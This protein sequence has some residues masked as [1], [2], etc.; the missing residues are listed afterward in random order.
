MPLRGTS[1]AWRRPRSIPSN[2]TDPRDLRASPMIAR[3]VVVLPTPFRPSSAAHSPAFTVRLTPCRICS[4][5]ICTWTS[6]SLSM[7]RLLDEVLVFG[8]AEIGL[9][10]T[11]V[12]I[13]HWFLCTA[14]CLFVG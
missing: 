6:S 2:S 13:S 11:L 1:W 5:P 9:A 3:K 10:H 8:A 14:L 7:H 4:L 12:H